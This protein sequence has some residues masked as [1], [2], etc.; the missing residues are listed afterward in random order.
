MTHVRRAV[1]AFGV[2]VAVTAPARADDAADAQALVE[3][4]IKAQGGRDK[5][6]KFAGHITKFKGSFH[7]M[8]QAIPITGEISTQ[9]KDKFRMDAEVEA[10]GMKFQFVTVYSGDKGWTKMGDKTLDMDKDQLAS[11]AEQTYAAWVESLTPLK[12]KQ[13][14]LS[15]TGET[16]VNDKPALG[17]KVTS[18]G[19]HD[20]DLY[21]DKETG[22]LVKRE[23]QVKNEGA[24]QEV[25]EETFPSEYKD[26][27][28]T[29]QAMKFTI[30][31]DGKLYVEGEA[32]EMQLVEKLD[33]NLFA[34][35]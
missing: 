33:A 18:K 25:T 16:K 11:A 10:G 13:F 12:D 23:T 24:D 34:K 2:A 4:A 21:F 35:P 6:D 31:R 8:G 26:V 29:K 19:H 20:V 22:L 9:G 5:L 32:T 30:K 28:G 17:V 7:G 3:K 15:T 1:L 14:T 27:Q